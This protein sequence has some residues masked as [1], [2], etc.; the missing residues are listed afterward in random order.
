MWYRGIFC[1]LLRGSFFLDTVPRPVICA[2]Q[3]WHSL[4]STDFV[5]I[6][7]QLPL[8]VDIVVSSPEAED[9]EHN[10]IPRFCRNKRERGNCKKRS[11]DR[12]TRRQETKVNLTSWKR[13]FPRCVSHHGDS[14]TGE[15][16]EESSHQPHC[17][18]DLFKKRITT[19]ASVV[20][21]LQRD[22]DAVF[23]VCSNARRTHEHITPKI[24]FKNCRLCVKLENIQYGENR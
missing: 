14:E 5:D 11:T 24:Y 20:L 7:N 12:R 23:G 15:A 6:L 1:T 9:G 4:V 18:R 16:T 3:R 19:E 13:N 10:M 2:N 17:S 21:F 8:C 22:R